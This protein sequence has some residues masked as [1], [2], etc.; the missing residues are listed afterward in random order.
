MGWCQIRETQPVIAAHD[1]AADAPA[2]FQQ[3][4]AA[5]SNRRSNTVAIRFEP[6]VDARASHIAGES[7]CRG[8]SFSTAKAE[9]QAAAL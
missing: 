1:G 4:A 6:R 2:A 8:T 5:A 7:Y 3:P 9:N